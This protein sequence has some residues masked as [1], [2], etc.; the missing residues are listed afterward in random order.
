MEISSLASYHNKD[1]VKKDIDDL[2]EHETFAGSL[3]AVAKSSPAQV[4]L[5]LVTV[6]GS[7]LVADDIDMYE[8]PIGV[9]LK[10][11]YPLSSPYCRIVTP[12]GYSVVDNCSIVQPN[13]VFSPSAVS[14]LSGWSTAAD[15]E[16]SL[17]SLLSDILQCCSENIPIRPILKTPSI[18]QPSPTLSQL[19]QQLND[20]ELPTELPSKPDDVE[21]PSP[22]TVSQLEQQ[23]Q[24]LNDDIQ[25]AEGIRET[26]PTD[27]IPED[28]VTKTSQLEEQLRE[29]NDPTPKDITNSVEDVPNIVPQRVDDGIDVSDLETI[30]LQEQEQEPEQIQ[31][32]IPQPD[33]N[34]VDAAQLQ[35]TVE[36]TELNN[37]LTDT[38]PA[39]EEPKPEEVHVADLD[40]P[41]VTLENS[42]VDKTLSAKDT[43][44]D[45]AEVL[46]GNP[47]EKEPA[48]SHTDIALP[49]VSLVDS[50]TTHQVDAVPVN[51]IGIPHQAFL[52][53]ENTA[54]S[55]VAEVEE[56]VAAPVATPQMEEPTLT[57]PPAAV[58]AENNESG[59]IPTSAFLP[60]S[61]M[62]QTVQPVD[63]TSPIS[64]HSL[65]ANSPTVG[66]GVV[67]SKVFIPVDP[68]AGPT[69]V[70]P[71]PTLSPFGGSNG[72]PVPAS[73]SP[74]PDQLQALFSPESK[75]SNNE[76]ENNQNTQQ[77]SEVYPTK[78][79][80]DD[81]EKERQELLAIL[82]PKMASDLVDAKK[83]SSDR[84]SEWENS[85]REIVREETA[86]FKEKHAA[87]IEAVPGVDEAIRDAK[88]AEE[89]AQNFIKASGETYMDLIQPDCP[90]GQQCL[91]YWALDN[92]LEDALRA[93][94]QGLNTGAITPGQF[95]RALLDT[96]RK[97][98]EARSIQNKITKIYSSQASFSENK[99]GALTELLTE[100]PSKPRSASTVRTA[101]DDI[102]LLLEEFPDFDPVIVVDVYYNT[103]QSMERSMNRLQELK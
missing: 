3:K 65:S 93:L 20:L 72:S 83:A 23:L 37:Q 32:P 100:R 62:T 26:T 74:V 103:G 11:D 71:S 52:P 4:G 25:P 43:D 19:E 44:L 5:T 34:V 17:V 60:A 45:Q 85:K 22:S 61:G 88:L 55:A 46:L 81:D 92:A 12:E 42:S 91:E 66:E 53:N 82:L 102:N 63:T 15:S 95:H 9:V 96:A 30:N 76:K 2:L 1:R 56:I 35:E 7:F 78:S 47:V 97:Q 14:S 87:F 21:D 48:A 49:E 89:R 51:E 8:I 75:G 40:I 67:T 10:P 80:G 101:E 41:E 84:L 16:R 98:F 31:E 79:E 68:N 90:L 39:P 70:V 54:S 94:D 58:G 38:A 69:N 27:S 13:G 18:E 73:N 36:V 77:L 24:D 99:P 6:E 59:G 57:Q 50:A 64:L 86:M 29:L 28:L 33:L